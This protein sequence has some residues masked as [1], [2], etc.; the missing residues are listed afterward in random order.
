[1]LETVVA[2]AKKG[3]VDISRI[4]KFDINKR[5]LKTHLEY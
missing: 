5:L 3:A 1:M 4:L 2:Q